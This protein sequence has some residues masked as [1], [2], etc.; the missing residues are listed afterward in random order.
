MT[1]QRYSTGHAKLTRARKNWQAIEKKTVEPK[2]ASTVGAGIKATRASL[3]GTQVKADK[4]KKAPINKR[5]TISNADKW[6]EDDHAIAEGGVGGKV[7]IHERLQQI[8][9]EYGCGLGEAR[10]IMWQ[11]QWG[12][13]GKR[14]DDD[15]D[16]CVQPARPANPIAD[17]FGQDDD[18]TSPFATLGCDEPG[19]Q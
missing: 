12:T 7:P 18:G 17:Q 4:A 1:K 8:R 9:I 10:R 16:V 6:A 3:A 13:T 15:T 19:L 11:E 5:K 14:Q 2:K